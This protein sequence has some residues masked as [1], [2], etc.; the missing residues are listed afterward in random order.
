LF[1]TENEGAMKLAERKVCEVQLYNYYCDDHCNGDCQ[2]IYGP[3]AFGV[4]NGSC[5]HVW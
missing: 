4:C 1:V 5:L 2:K 3:K